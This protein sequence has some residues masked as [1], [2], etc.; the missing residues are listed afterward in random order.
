MT[1]MARWQQRL[2]NFDRA[3][4]NLIAASAIA[5]P[6][7]VEKAGVIHLFELAFELSWKTLKDHLYEQGTVVKSPRETIKTAYQYEYIT[8]G[9]VWINILETHNTLSHTYDSIA[10]DTGYEEIVFR[11]IAALQQVQ[12][13]FHTKAVL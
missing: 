6:S 1:E 9:D 10:A 4:N 5:K 7:E 3:M 13:F 11:F 8:D 12:Q 2:I